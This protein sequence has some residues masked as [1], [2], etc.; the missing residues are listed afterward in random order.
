MH[1]LTQLGF[2]FLQRPDVQL[3]PVRKVGSLEKEEHLPGMPLLSKSPDPPST[4]REALGPDFSPMS[5]SAVSDLRKT[6][7]GPPRPSDP[8]DSLQ[9]TA[10][11]SHL[12]PVSTSPGYSDE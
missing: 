6:Q 1:S 10:L 8:T 4:P 11:L 3:E 9:E 7:L 5:S 12:E 2:W